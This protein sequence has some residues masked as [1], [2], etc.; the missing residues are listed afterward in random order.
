[1]PPDVLFAGVA[2][3]DFDAALLWYTNLFGRSADIVAHD[4][5]VMW[6]V[7][8]GAWIYVIGDPSHAGHA[9][10]AW[11]VADLRE[12]IATLEGRGIAVGPI[13][14]LGGGMRA[15]V[16]DLEGNTVAFIEVAQP[17]D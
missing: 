4:R 1:V 3:A 14:V 9:L 5:E 8:E 7:A 2:V 11:A 17:E 13:E 6:R 12:T 10:V 15:S 16:R